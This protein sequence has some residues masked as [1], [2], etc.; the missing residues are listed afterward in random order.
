MALLDNLVLRVKAEAGQTTITDDVGGVLFNGDTGTAAIFDDPTYGKLWR[1]TGGK[2]TAALSGFPA[3][4]VASGE[5][6]TTLVARF[7]ISAMVG[8][9]KF[10]GYGTNYDTGLFFGG[11]GNGAVDITAAPY[12]LGNPEFSCIPPYTAGT[13]IT[14]VLRVKKRG[15][16]QSRNDLWVGQA[17]RAGTA[18]DINLTNTAFIY[19][20]SSVFA[21]FDAGTETLDILDYAVF[22]RGLTDAEAAAVAD[23][24]RG[25]LYPSAGG[26]DATAPGATLTG[27]A[28]LTPG[29]ATGASAGSAPGANLTGTATLT[30]GSATG[31]AAPTTGSFA[32]E[33]MVNNS[34]SLLASVAV[35]W[36]WRKGSGIGVAPT[37]VV[38]GSGTTSPAGVL[39]ASGLPLGT[40]ELLVATP[41]YASVYYQRGAVT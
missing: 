10:V 11:R 2:K 30:P 6:Y 21:S 18:A 20:R 12:G 36:E 26:S 33:I 5:T 40:G 3:W 1:V 29:S 13:V 24:P 34:G 23:D 35:L 22:T 9:T 7:R 17:G 39:T 31:A 14:L 8:Y 15:S 41:D 28:T 32:S 27:T 37:S 19:D 25:Q 38:Y 16:G 4:S